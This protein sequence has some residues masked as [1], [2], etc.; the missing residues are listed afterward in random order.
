MAFL[1]FAMHCDIYILI[2]QKIYT[3]PQRPAYCT[4]TYLAPLFGSSVAKKNSQRSI[5]NNP[6]HSDFRS[7]QPNRI[8]PGVVSLSNFTMG[9][10]L[11]F[12]GREG[13][14][15]QGLRRSS[16]RRDSGPADIPGKAK[17]TL[18]QQWVWVEV[19]SSAIY[20]HERETK[21]GPLNLQSTSSIAAILLHTDSRSHQILP[22]WLRR[23]ATLPKNGLVARTPRQKWRGI[24]TMC[25]CI[26]IY[27]GTCLR[28]RAHAI[29]NTVFFC[30]VFLM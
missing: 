30:L 6:I 12:P 19:I 18:K 17:R 23:R 9:S 27:V 8:K 5:T 7:P 13:A 14:G 10:G 25:A 28:A 22:P 3:Y 29:A 11:S 15:K 4:L 1:P 2:G 20:I 21:S 24:R 16:T 26:Y